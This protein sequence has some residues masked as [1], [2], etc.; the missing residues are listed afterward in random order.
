LVAS[1]N[2]YLG[3]T[4]TGSSTQGVN[5]TQTGTN[6]LNAANTALS[7][8][9]GSNTSSGTNTQNTTGTQNQTGTTTGSSTGA[10][11]GFQNLVSNNKE[12]TSGTA[13]GTGNTSASGLIPQAQQVQTGGGGC[14]ICTAGLTHGVFTTPRLLRFVVAHKLQKDWT[15]FRHA[16]RGYFFLFTP[17][18]RFLLS[19]PLLAR[20]SMPFAKSVVYEEARIA[21]KNLPFKLVPWFCHWTWHA[22]CA[23]VGRFPVPDCVTDPRVLDAA[24]RHNVLFRVGGA[25]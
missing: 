21:G 19:H 5:T 18:A 14:V 4:T 6:F 15:R 9:T 24:R 20:W 1:G 13:T 12:N 22:G 16:A 17:I 3:Q 7:N 23:V 11:T 25:K 10:T 2:P 8:V